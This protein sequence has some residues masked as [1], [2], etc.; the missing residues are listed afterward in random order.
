MAGMFRSVPLLA[1][2]VL[3]IAACGGDDDDVAESPDTFDCDAVVLDEMDGN[4]T[5]YSGRNEELVAPLIECF[6]DKSGVDT[7]VRYAGS[8]EMA[9]QIS[10]EGDS[11]EAD[12]FFSQTPGALGLLESEE[13]LAPLPESILS[14]VDPEYRSA[15]GR[16]VGTSGRVRTFAYNTET[17]DAAELPETIDDVL[18]PEWRGRLGVV[19]SNASFIDFVAAMVLDRGEDGAREF[20][21]GL[22]ANDPTVLPTNT[23]AVEAAAR[24][25]VDGALVNHYY[26]A[27]MLVGD[28]DLPVA[29]HFF[30]KGDIGSYVLVA[31]AGILADAGDEQPEAEAFVTYLLSQPAQEYFRDE[32]QEYPLSAGVEPGADLPQLTTVGFENTDEAALGAVNRTAVALIEESGLAG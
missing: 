30:E 6:G 28:P 31:G 32:T 12:V 2:A 17:V 4:L 14:Q 7:E 19:P 23:A 9:L 15:D 16:W 3:L 27:R 11:T 24:G 26:A 18:D 13:L 22:E 1:T 5:V 20:L 29:N 21:E 8:E 25:Q 10:E